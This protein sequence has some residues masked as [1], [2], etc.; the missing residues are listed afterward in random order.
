[1][2]G[3]FF[4][5]EAEILTTGFL[6]IDL[7]YKGKD[8]L[9]MSIET[10]IRKLNWNKSSIYITDKEYFNF[11]FYDVNESQYR[12]SQ[13]VINKTGVGSTCNYA[14]IWGVQEIFD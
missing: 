5:F 14:I 7:W 12:T 6:E 10:N 8:N 3:V 9:I 11:V 4:R 2:D 13:K 1:M